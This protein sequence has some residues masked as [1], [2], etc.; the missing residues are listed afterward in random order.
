MT[1]IHDVASLSGFSVSTVSRALSGRGS[2]KKETMDAILKAA[3]VLHYT[4]NVLAQGLKEGLT[5]T[6]GMIIP[7]INNPVFPEVARGAEDAA[8]QL[9]YQMYLCNTGEDLEVEYQYIKSLISRNVDGILLIT[10]SRENF[11]VDQLLKLGVPLVVLVRSYGTSSLVDKISIDN[12]EVGYL[13]GQRLLE[14]GCKRLCI[15]TGDIGLDVYRYRMEGFQKAIQEAG[16]S[17]DTS[18]V[19]DGSKT[20]NNGYDIIESVWSGNT[21]FD[22]IFA[23]CDFQSLGV[24]KFF[25]TQGIPVPEEVA[26]VGVDNLNLCSMCNPSIT[27]IR[28][29]LYDCGALASNKLIQRLKER[30]K[31]CEEIRLTPIII[32]GETA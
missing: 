6:I 20:R 2:V 19:L 32:G 22:G 4:P 11:Y 17:V 23:S 16:L 3:E 8:R 5:R 13:A 12:I 30:S 21:R 9:G 29:P 26:I 14:S 25:E 7:D 27:A 10:A 31:E 15:L 28:Q 18:L 24:L 1:T